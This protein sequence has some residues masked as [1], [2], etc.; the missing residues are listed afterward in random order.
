MDSRVMESDRDDQL[1]VV[2]VKR[3]AL[4]QSGSHDHEK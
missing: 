2:P 4:R 1:A 3:F